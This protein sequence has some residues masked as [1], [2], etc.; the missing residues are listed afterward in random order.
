VYIG[1]QIV[2]TPGSYIPQGIHDFASSITTIVSLPGQAQEVTVAVCASQDILRKEL[3]RRIANGYLETINTIPSWKPEQFQAGWRAITPELLAVWRLIE[4]VPVPGIETEEPLPFPRDPKTASKAALAQAYSWLYLAIAACDEMYEDSLEDLLKRYVDPAVII[5]G[6]LQE[7]STQAESFFDKKLSLEI[8]Y[9]IAAVQASVARVLGMANPKA[10]FWAYLFFKQ[11]LLKPVG[12]LI[13]SKQRAIETISYK[14]AWDAILEGWL[15]AERPDI[16]LAQKEML[17]IQAIAAEILEIPSLIVD[18]LTKGY[19]I[20]GNPE[21][22]LSAL[23][24]SLQDLWTRGFHG[25]TLAEGVRPYINSLE[26]SAGTSSLLELADFMI[27]LDGI[28]T[29]YHAEIEVWLGSRLKEMREPKLFLDRIGGETQQWELSLKPE[30]RLRLWNER[31]NALRLS[32]HPKEALEITRGIAALSDVLTEHDRKILMLNYGILLR[33]NGFL[34]KSWVI[35]QNLLHEVDDIESV[36]PLISFAATCLSLG[37]G[38]EALYYLDLAEQRATGP[39]AQRKELIR[40]TKLMALTSLS[41]YEEALDIVESDPFTSSTSST[42]TS[43]LLVYVILNR[44]DLMERISTLV[45]IAYDNLHATMVAAAER[46]DSQSYADAY[47]CVAHLTQELSEKDAASVWQQYF[48]DMA[49]KGLLGL[50]EPTDVLFRSVYLYKS[51]DSQDKRREILRLVADQLLRSFIPLTDRHLTIGSAGPHRTALA[52][53]SS[54]IL[55]YDRSDAHLRFAAEL[56]RDAIGRSQLVRKMSKSRKYLDAL[57]DER[58]LLSISSVKGRVGILERLRATDEIVTLLTIVGSDSVQAHFLDNWEGD[59]GTL[60]RRLKA[61]LFN[62]TDVNSDP[63]DYDPW[64][65]FSS[66]LT[67]ELG[68]FIKNGDHLV[69][70]NQELFHGLPIHVA[71]DDLCTSSYASGYVELL[72]LLESSKADVRTSTIFICPRFNE[73]HEIERAFD[74]FSLACQQLLTKSNIIVEIIS[75]KEADFE[76]LKD[77]LRQTDLLVLLCHGFVS[78]PAGDVGLILSADGRLPLASSVAA[79]NAVGLPHRMMWYDVQDL[80]RSPQYVFSAACSSGSGRYGGLGEQ[81]DF[82]TGFRL[83]GT[84]ALIAPRWDVMADSVL[85]VFLRTLDLTLHNNGSLIG[86]LREASQEA[87]KSFGSK[88]ASWSL[89]LQ[90][91]WR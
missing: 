64:V 18:V 71:V 30:L 48:T 15:K 29:P 41:R 79:S 65:K 66:F 37:R 74:A 73:S 21:S 9:S 50:V 4:T 53:F 42:T 69:L 63:F 68:K 46:G 67:S 14:C 78:W 11:Q 90:G 6:A 52:R 80:E 44:P 24:D 54:S 43:V 57:L 2:T 12:R 56:G 62:W 23:K 28:H 86:S 36:D 39:F 88:W 16:E 47:R 34:D 87:M 76:H 31:S 45:P 32:G 60:A 1:G 91:D 3:A 72:S 25:S 38:E 55:D 51:A 5:D 81:L 19:Q 33:D 85:S 27:S 89:A 26:G 20:S 61:R 13:I 82:F 77:A 22:L 75:G 8:S 35:L 40:Q 83:S 70:M 49:A 84:K 59:E 58:S 7:F 10:V 17:G